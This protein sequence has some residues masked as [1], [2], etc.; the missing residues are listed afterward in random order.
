M[1]RSRSVSPPVA[2]LLLTLVIAA[3]LILGWFILGRQEQIDPAS[4][5]H[6]KQTGAPVAPVAIPAG[7]R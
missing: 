2:A 6:G 1:D 3:A 4:L 7:S 5:H